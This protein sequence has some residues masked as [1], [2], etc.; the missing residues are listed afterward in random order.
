MGDGGRPGAAHAGGGRAA[1]RR[2]LHGADHC[3]PGV[4]A[5]GGCR[6]PVGG[7]AGGRCRA[8]VH[9]LYNGCVDIKAF[10]NQTRALLLE[11]SLTLS[12]DCMHHTLRESVV[13][14]DGKPREVYHFHLQTALVASVGTPSARA[15]TSPLAHC[16]SSAPPSAGVEPNIILVTTMMSAARKAGRW[17][18]ALLLFEQCGELGLQPDVAA[19]NAA[20]TACASA[21]AW[22]RAWAIFSGA[23][24]PSAF[25]G[26][27]ALRPPFGPS[28]GGSRVHL[29]VSLERCRQAPAARILQDVSPAS[30]AG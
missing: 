28:Y 15:Q 1:G 4:Q 8:R 22:E 17:Q 21:G 11:L 30:D 5:L 29:P 19:F 24:H 14:E 18:H 25:A 26:N 9:L 27:E 12:S 3:V 6:A 20:I 7:D 13:C 23:L 2:D 10:R 16:V